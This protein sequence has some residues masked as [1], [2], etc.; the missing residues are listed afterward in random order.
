VPLFPTLQPISVFLVTT[1]LLVLL[2][3]SVALLELTN[4]FTAHPPSINVWLAP[5]VTTAPPTRPTRLVS[6]K[7]VTTVFSTALFLTLHSASAL[8]ALTVQLDLPITLFALLDRTATMFVLLLR[9]DT[10]V[11]DTTAFATL[12]LLLPLT[13]SLVLSVP[14]VTTVRQTLPVRLPVSLVPMVQAPVKDQSSLAS[15]VLVVA[16]AQQTQ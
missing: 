6:A 13:T 10:A 1:A 11:L 5:L 4:Q 16:T 9:L 7:L 2:L 15:L 14:L 12:R 8:L 3:P